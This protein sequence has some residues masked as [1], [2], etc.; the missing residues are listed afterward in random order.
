M[1]KEIRFVD[2]SA[3]SKIQVNQESMEYLM[4][5]KHF[6]TSML[7]ESFMWKILGGILWGKGLH[8][9]GLMVFDGSK[10][11]ARNIVNEEI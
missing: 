2:K 4:V 1:E 9:K 8:E 7:E 10:N 11:T 5:W 6:Q 3:E